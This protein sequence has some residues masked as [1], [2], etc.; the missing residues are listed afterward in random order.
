MG[1][2]EIVRD[3]RGEKGG[4]GQQ[5]GGRGREG[6]EVKGNKEERKGTGG[7]EERYRGRKDSC[8]KRGERWWRRGGG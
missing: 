8:R 4:G 1:D 7:E 2:V 5:V 3:K 6:G